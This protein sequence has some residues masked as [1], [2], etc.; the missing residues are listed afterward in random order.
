MDESGIIKVSPLL[1]YFIHSLLLLSRGTFVDFTPTRK[2]LFR[3]EIT[4][5]AVTSKLEVK[6]RRSNK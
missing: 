5:F 2:T 3:A 6:I 4:Y 1:A